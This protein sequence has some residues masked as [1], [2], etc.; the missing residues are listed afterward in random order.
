MSTLLAL[1]AK[2][3]TVLEAME[4][5]SQVSAGD[6]RSDAD[7]YIRLLED[8]QF[9]DTL[10]AAQ[11]ILVYLAPVI[12]SLQAKDCT[13]AAAYKDVALARARECFRRG[14]NDLSWSRVGS[15]IEKLARSVET[16]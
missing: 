11:V 4:S 13:L 1:I 6:A 7:P 16:I 14:R 10:A 12:K 2:Y 8:Q 5:I 3:A 15:K 9:V